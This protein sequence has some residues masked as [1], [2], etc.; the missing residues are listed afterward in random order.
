MKTEYTLTL[1][2][3]P[4]ATV[5]TTEYDPDTGREYVDPRKVEKIEIDDT[6]DIAIYL[7]DISGG[8]M[9]ACTEEFDGWGEDEQTSV[10]YTREAAEKAIKED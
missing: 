2:C 6:G 4:G 9:S 10:Y 5:Y 7:I 8:R 1:P 3:A